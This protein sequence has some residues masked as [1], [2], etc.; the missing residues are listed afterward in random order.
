MGGGGGGG[1]TWVSPWDSPITTEAQLPNMAK[2]AANIILY[3]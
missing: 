1:G 3:S 2:Q